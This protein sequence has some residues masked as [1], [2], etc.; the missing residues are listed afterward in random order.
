MS[1][2]RPCP[3]LRPS[4]FLK[5]EGTRSPRA[6]RRLLGYGRRKLGTSTLSNISNVKTLLSLRFGS[7]LYQKLRLCQDINVHIVIVNK[8]A[9]LYAFCA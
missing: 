4:T 3:P 8:N 2:L 5:D 9:Q 7:F 1:C 6:G